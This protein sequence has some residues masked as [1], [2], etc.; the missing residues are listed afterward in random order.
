MGTVLEALWNRIARYRSNEPVR[1]LYADGGA[2]TVPADTTGTDQ[3]GPATPGED[4]SRLDPET[5][6]DDRGSFCQLTFEERT[7][8]TT[9][10]FVLSYLD[11]HDG[12]LRQQ[13]LVECLPWS[14]STVSRLLSGL[15]REGRV[16]RRSLG[17]EN[18][19]FLPEAA[20]GGD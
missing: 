13:A 3:S 18:A 7:G 16:V 15:E 5:L 19:V 14:A 11:R 9:E 4:V 6:C 1:R 10:A 8:Y 2:T 17:R 20:P 12:A